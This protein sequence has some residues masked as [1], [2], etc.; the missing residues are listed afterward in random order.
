MG[1]APL[2]G[3]AMS[4]VDLSQ[5]VRLLLTAA[6][7]SAS[8]TSIGADDSRTDRPP[9]PALPERA[10]ASPP[11]EELPPQGDLFIVLGAAGAPEYVDLFQDWGRRWREAGEQGGWRCHTLGS[12]VDAAPNGDEAKQSLRSALQAAA[13]EPALPLWI[14]LIGHGTDNGRV[15]K[16]NLAGEDVSDQELDEWLSPLQRPIAILNTSSASG[17]MLPALS[18][19]GRVVVVA[20]K[21]GQEVN[22]ARFGGYL[23]AALT[24]PQADLDKDGQVSLL[25]AFLRAARQTAE[26][27]EGANRLATEHALI[28]DNGDKRGSRPEAFA[29]IR[30]VRETGAADALDGYVAHQWTLI[31]SAEERRFPP[32]LRRRRDEL[33]LSILRL[34]DQKSEYELDDYY[35]RLEPLLLEMARLYSA[36]EKSDQ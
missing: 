34:R 12:V 21:N 15:A 10:A 5:A 3:P 27:Y 6:C 9:R 2:E 25:E 8:L 30:P 22:F 19:P 18:G 36:V 1:A 11:P 17:A 24:E 31:P 16:F 32:E 4:S 13:A 33:E 23:A 14:V 28:D 29:G 7:L 26:F 35:A 20:T